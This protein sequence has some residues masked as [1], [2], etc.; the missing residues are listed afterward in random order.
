MYRSTILSLLAVERVSQSLSDT[1][2]HCLEHCETPEEEVIVTWVAT[3]V[4][5]GLSSPLGS[6]LDGET[7]PRLAGI[8]GR[9]GA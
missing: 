1:F 7:V 6:T 8:E 2:V 9:V 4:A 5:Y 3:H